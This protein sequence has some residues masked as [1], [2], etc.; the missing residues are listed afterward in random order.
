MRVNWNIA[1]VCGQMLNIPRYQVSTIKNK[2]AGGILCRQSSLIGN[3][4]QLACL[5]LPPLMQ[6]HH[7]SWD[8]GCYGDRGREIELGDHCKTLQWA[9]K[10]IFS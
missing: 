4:G 5:L 1:H 6:P 2:L 10:D 8:A 3:Q 9:L 7:L